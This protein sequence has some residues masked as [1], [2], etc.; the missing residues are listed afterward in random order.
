MKY[1]DAK[2]IYIFSLLIGLTSLAI[3]FYYRYSYINFLGFNRPLQ[4]SC[5][6]C[7]GLGIIGAI[8]AIIDGVNKHFKGNILLIL[9]LN[10]VMAMANP[11]LVA[12]EGSLQP[13]ENPYQTASPEKGIS[14]KFKSDSS[15]IIEG[16]LYKFPI[17][18][19]DFVDRDFSYSLNEKDD[20]LV[21]TINKKGKSFEAKPTWFTDGEN[22][23]VYKEFYLLEAIFDKDT[24]REK[25]EDLPIERL[26][27]SVINNNRDFEIRGIMLE[28][29]MYDIKERFKEKIT[30]DD[31]NKDRPIKSYYLD[32]NDGYQIRLDALNGNVQSIQIYKK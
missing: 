6:I 2:K 16:K 32:T 21:A 14:T 18:L 30:E 19:K 28:D 27:A 15:F 31:A 29:S 4:L 23:E 5:L 25:I 7:A 13:I 26:I 9:I 12:I 3:G 24:D 10:L 17:K 8:V 22:K 20:K 11:I 1:F